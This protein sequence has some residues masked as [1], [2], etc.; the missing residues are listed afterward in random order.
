MH[1]GKISI[2]AE[3]DQRGLA[4]RKN[5]YCFSDHNRLGTCSTDPTVQLTISG[6]HRF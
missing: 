1:T 2:L 4:C 5:F 6:D 3:P